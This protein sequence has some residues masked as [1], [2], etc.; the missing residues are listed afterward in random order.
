[1][2]KYGTI[3]IVYAYDDSSK[4][5][6]ESVLNGHSIPFLIKENSFF[7]K[8]LSKKNRDEISKQLNE[9]DLTFLLFHNNNSDGDKI[10]GGNL[11]HE[12]RRAIK[13]YIIDE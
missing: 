7:F 10:K 2:P 8:T 9:L 1:M 13:S 5:S 6:I 4:Q 12:E 11:P 3:I